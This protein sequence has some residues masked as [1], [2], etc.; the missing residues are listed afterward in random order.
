MVSDYIRDDDDLLRVDNADD[1][2]DGMLNDNF[3]DDGTS[4][5]NNNK[6]GSDVTEDFLGMFSEHS[7]DSFGYS[8]EDI[9]HAKVGIKTGQNM[10]Q[11]MGRYMGQFMAENTDSDD[12]VAQA[13]MDGTEKASPFD[14]GF[15]GSS[16]YGVKGLG[17]DVSGIQ[18]KKY[19]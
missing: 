9:V 7:P 12:F 6:E 11:D 3:G 8:N 15:G 14:D 4:S 2:E 10:G 5:S 19:F 13:K 1:T 16:Q 18:R 17:I